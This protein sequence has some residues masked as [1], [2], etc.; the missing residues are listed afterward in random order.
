MNKLD[1]A[2]GVPPQTTLGNEDLVR[3]LRLITNEYELH[4]KK[5][6]LRV[7]L[8]RK[9]TTFRLQLGD[10]VFAQVNTVEVEHAIEELVIGE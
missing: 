6:S 2:K 8:H 10:L 5:T 7:Q 9:K 3:V 4:R 1:G